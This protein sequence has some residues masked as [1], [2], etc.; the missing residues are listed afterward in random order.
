MIDQQRD[1]P[2]REGQT[3]AFIAYRRKLASLAA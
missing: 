2:T 3:T 1:I